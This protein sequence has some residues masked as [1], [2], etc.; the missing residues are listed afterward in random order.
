MEDVFVLIL[1]VGCLEIEQF[2]HERKAKSICFAIF[3]L[4]CGVMSWLCTTGFDSKILL[5][6]H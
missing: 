4:F 3:E 1:E 5:L 6:N 2:W